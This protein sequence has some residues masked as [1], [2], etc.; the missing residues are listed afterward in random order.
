MPSNYSVPTPLEYFAALVQVGQGDAIA[1]L[2][3]AA[4]IAHDAHPHL[5][6]QQFLDEMDRLQARLERR[7]PDG[8]LKV[9]VEM[10]DLAQDR[11]T[12]LNELDLTAQTPFNEEYTLRT[13]GTWQRE[14]DIKGADGK[15]LKK[16]KPDGTPSTFNQ[17]E[18]VTYDSLD[19]IPEKDRWG[20]DRIAVV[21]DMLPVRD[22]LKRQ[23]MLEASDAPPAMIEDHRKRLNAAY[24]AFKKKHGNLHKAGNAKIAMTMPD[25][26]LA[27][28]VVGGLWLALW[29]TRVRRWGLLPI[30]AGAAWALS[31]PA[32]DLL[33]TGDG[34]HLALRT[35]QGLAL[36]PPTD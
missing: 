9:V 12:I 32:P 28:M 20:A 10:D 2:E 5:D 23:L 21:T 26:A 35:P 24:D 15:P 22:A 33:V 34:R 19:K 1:L 27:L 11:K 16:L 6:V 8:A 3:A 17:K 30:A 29:R 31:T 36:P 18:I 4:C 25:G 14:V 7:M 13:D